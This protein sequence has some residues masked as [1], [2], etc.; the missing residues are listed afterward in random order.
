MIVGRV[1]QDEYQGGVAVVFAVADACTDLERDF[2]DEEAV[3]AVEREEV[4]GFSFVPFLGS[5][6]QQLE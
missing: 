6:C 5:T 3:P 2:V 4:P 1:G